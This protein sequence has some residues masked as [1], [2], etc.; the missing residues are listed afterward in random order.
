MSL[1][2]NRDDINRMESH[3]KIMKDEAFKTQQSIQIVPHRVKFPLILCCWF[4]SAVT[5]TS[6]FVSPQHAHRVALRENSREPRVGETDDSDQVTYKLVMTATE[7][8]LRECGSFYEAQKTGQVEE[9]R[10]QYKP[11]NTQGISC[12]EEPSQGTKA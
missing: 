6:S 1:F 8:L 7:T 3:N 12:G 9:H 2:L 11:R 10:T 4:I 5:L